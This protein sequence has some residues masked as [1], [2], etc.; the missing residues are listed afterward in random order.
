MAD[1]TATSPSVVERPNAS[2]MRGGPF[3]RLQQYSHLIGEEQWNLG[4]RL[5]FVI[6]IGWVPLLIIKLLFDRSN[7]VPFLRDYGLNA[8]MFIAVPVLIIG[9]PLMEAHFHLIVEHV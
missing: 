7:L 2:L 8:R 6:A 9:Q 3:Y 1:Q 5:I 4:R